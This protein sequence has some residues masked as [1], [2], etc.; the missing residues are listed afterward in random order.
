MAGRAA[1]Y[2]VNLNFVF[3]EFLSGWC[4][5]RRFPAYILR[6]VLIAGLT[7]GVSRAAEQVAAPDFSVGS[8]LAFA[9]EDF[10]GDSRPDLASVQGGVESVD[11]DSVQSG[12][13]DLGADY[14]VRLQ[15]STARTQTFRIVAPA[16][17]IEIASRDVNGDHVVDLVLTGAWIAQPVAI[18][19]NDGHGIFSRID[20]A[21]FPEAFKEY[22]TSWNI[23]DEHATGAAGSASLSRD[24][25]P[26]KDFCFYERPRV[27]LA[28]RRDSRLTSG[29]PLDS[30]SGRAP[31]CKV[32]HS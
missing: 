9:V 10:D 13:G 29:Q 30:H 31:P 12:A 6:L 25:C 28:V 1:V 4:V 2:R 17:G 20:P 23:A 5:G 15:L 24:W 19:L 3:S 11:Q 27:L 14:W 22:R 32:T 26:G 16:G 18:L 21:A 8:G 7:G